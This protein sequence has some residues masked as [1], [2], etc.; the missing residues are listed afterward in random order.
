MKIQFVLNHFLSLLKV[1][2]KN[3][4]CDKSNLNHGHVREKES[5]K[6]RELECY[7]LHNCG[8]IQNY[9][10]IPSTIN[11]DYT[12]WQLSTL[13]TLKQTLTVC[14]L[15]ILINPQRYC[16]NF[17]YCPEIPISPKTTKIQD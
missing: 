17:Q 2:K 1:K 10:Y 14:L 4:A 15:F 11:T 3:L 5:L 9:M 12:V 7:G 13:K 6:V 16:R 8:I